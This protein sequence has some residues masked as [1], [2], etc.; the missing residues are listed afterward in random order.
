MWSHV[1]AQATDLYQQ[2]M[3]HKN[4]CFSFV[5]V[6]I[7]G[8]L[9]CLAT[10]ALAQWHSA[11]SFMPD[12][13]QR[14]VMESI[15]AE[16]QQNYVGALNAAKNPSVVIDKYQA[17]LN[18]AKSNVKSTEAKLDRVEKKYSGREGYLT[19]EQRQEVDQARDAYLKA[20]EKQRSLEMGLRLFKDYQA[21]DAEAKAAQQKVEQAKQ[22]R[23][24]TFQQWKQATNSGNKSQAREAYEKF[25][26]E[27]AEIK[28]LEAQ[29]AAKAEAA[30]KA[31]NFWLKMASLDDK[32]GLDERLDKAR[33]NIQNQ[34]YWSLYQIFDRTAQIRLPGSFLGVMRYG[35]YY[36]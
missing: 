7:S 10:P 3:A 21:K 5:L 15:Q 33:K 18:N 25:R 14:R 29:A 8:G 16:K 34:L 2:E 28:R 6:M 22:A 17:R 12:S 20:S 11:P 4:L 30:K 27:T 1:A 32:W 9:L 26:R 19:N 23:E 24:K 35:G 31:K 13:L 36:Q